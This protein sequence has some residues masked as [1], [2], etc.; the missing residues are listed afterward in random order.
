MPGFSNRLDESNKVKLNPGNME[1]LHV[2]GSVVQGN[3]V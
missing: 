3:G 1:L 2:D